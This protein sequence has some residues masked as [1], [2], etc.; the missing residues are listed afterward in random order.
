MKPTQLTTILIVALLEGCGSAPEASQPAPPSD[1]SSGDLFLEP[2]TYTARDVD[3][4]AQ[5]GWLT[6]PENRSDPDSR[7][8]HLPVTRVKALDGVGLQPI[9]YL[10]GGPG[11][12]NMGFS[13][14]EGL[15][16]RHDL[17]M[18]GYRGVDGPVR[19]ECPEYAEL[20]SSPP[21]SLLSQETFDASADAYRR[22]AQ[23]H[24]AEGVDLD[25]YTV[26]ETI[27][28]LEDA[29]HAF[30]D[31]RVNT[32]SQSYGTRL[33]MIWGWMYPSSQH[34][35]AMI[36]VNPPGHFIWDPGMIERQLE[37][38]SALCA[39][40]AQC[41]GRTDSLTE[42]MRSVSR[43]MP[44]RWLFLPVK[45][46]NIGMVT[47]MMLYHTT[48]APKILDAW[49]DA[50]E[51]DAS[52]LAT[53]SLMADLMF[54]SAPSVWG[55]SV[56]KVTSTDYTWDPS[57]D[58]LAEYMP[59]GAILGALVSTLGFAGARGW[60]GNL[61]DDELRQVQ[62]SAVETLLIRG[63]IDFS[64]PAEFARDELLPHL[65][66]GRQVILREFG[67][68]GDVWSLQPEAT[69]H[70]LAT[71]Y[72]TG[73]VDDSLFEVNSV[74][75][76]PGIGFGTMAKLALAGLL[77]VMVVVALVTRWAWRRLRKARSWRLPG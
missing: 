72:A 8:I 41:S 75:F 22:C 37:H 77:I 3:Y 20:L 55:E 19:L 32:L 52:G 6:V 49:L 58:Y 33:A 30:G 47:F 62:P 50:A 45:P 63:S 54:A 24:S 71:F 18:V 60:P 11:Q 61:I 43:S 4:S 39:A 59:E 15:I 36:S 53:L 10:A 34:R 40:D 31:P 64:T 74:D 26:T 65:E 44:E 69:R 46:G 51:G 70:L 27:D 66:N 17:V 35:S 67:H 5:C 2:C 29:R 7:L 68:T 48:S 13:R 25:G 14:L 38:Y 23:R 56:A 16:D 73:E 42:A 57:R 76:D 28:D 9:Y 12:T 1:A 21:A